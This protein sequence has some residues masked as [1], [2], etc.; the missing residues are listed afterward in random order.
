M[1]A[2]T[3]GYTTLAPRDSPTISVVQD[4]VCRLRKVLP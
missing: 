1:E 2:R 3:V 4:F